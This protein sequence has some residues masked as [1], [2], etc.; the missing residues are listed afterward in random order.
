M[1]RTLHMNNFYETSL[2]ISDPK[3]EFL[4]K[5]IFLKN[6]LNDHVQKIQQMCFWQEKAPAGYPDSKTKVV[7]I[8]WNIPDPNYI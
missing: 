1:V 2:Q 7:N 6:D 5:A 4:T 8:F 3:I